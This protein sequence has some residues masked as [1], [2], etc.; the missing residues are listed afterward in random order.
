MCETTEE[1]EDRLLD[2]HSQE[3]AAA[4]HDY[5][6]SGVIVLNHVIGLGGTGPAA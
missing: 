5:G 3:L 2:I 1:P 4:G 6:A